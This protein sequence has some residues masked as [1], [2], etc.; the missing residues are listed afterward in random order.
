LSG[1]ASDS[2]QDGDRVTVGNGGLQ[3]A[4]EADVLVVQVDVDEPAEVLAVNP[5]Q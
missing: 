2:R 5:P 3:A 4:E 1:P